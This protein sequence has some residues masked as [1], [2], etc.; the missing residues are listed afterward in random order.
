MAKRTKK[1]SKRKSD[2]NDKNS[3]CA[4]KSASYNFFTL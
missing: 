3:T 2:K 4:E 1:S